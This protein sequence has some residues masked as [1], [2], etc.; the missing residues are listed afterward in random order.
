[1]TTMGRIADPSQ[2]LIEFA[3]LLMGC[4]MLDGGRAALR[5]VLDGGRCGS[6]VASDR[7]SVRLRGRSG[8]AA[9]LVDGRS[10]SAVGAG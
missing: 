5:S 6:A 4:R 2:R 10:G 8:S 9:A 7:R 1:M 3:S